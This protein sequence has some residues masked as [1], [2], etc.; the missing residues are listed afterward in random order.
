MTG[1]VI[2]S[3]D[4]KK[5]EAFMRLFRPVHARLSQYV[6]AMVGDY[7]EAREILSETILTAYEQFETISDSDSFIYFLFTIAK[8]KYKRAMWRRKLFKAYDDALNDTIE[9][10]GPSPEAQADARLLR[11]A[12]AKLPPKQREAVSMFGIADMTLD[13]IASIQNSKLSAVKQRVRRARF[14]L[15]ELLGATLSKDE[16]ANVRKVKDEKESI[17]LEPEREER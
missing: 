4:I 1:S 14:K 6:H 2:E 11:D 17:D 15:A 9:G 12:L 10:D 13:E 8:R 5:Q 16:D 3:A 7:E